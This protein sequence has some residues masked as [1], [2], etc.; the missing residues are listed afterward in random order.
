MVPDA[1]L[2]LASERYAFDKATL[3]FISDSTNQVYGFSRDGKDYI[4]RVSRRPAEAV[5][6]MNAEIDWLY[7]LA[8]R[9]VGVSLPLRAD[10]GGLSVFTTDADS[11]L[12]FILCAFETA[13]GRFWDKNSPE[14]WNGRVFYNWGRAVGELHRLTKDYRP[15][16]PLD[17]RPRFT[18]REALSD[19]IRGCPELCRAADETSAEIMALPSDADSYGLIHCD[20][21]PWNFFIDGDR[22]NLFDFDD[23]LYGWFALDIGVALYHGLW[24]GRKNDAGHDFTNELV[25]RF[26]DGYLSANALDG[27]W[28]S[29][30]PLFMRY[31]QLCK[32]S[33]FFDP[34]HIDAH[35][36]ERIENVVNGVLFTGCELDRSLFRG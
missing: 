31:R 36:R 25:K 32:A 12:G 8:E 20:A 29:K 1:L 2:T 3:R 16:D 7:F 4:L 21:H 30:I 11:G 6:Q 28:L 33:W 5:R 24:W 15:S 35:Q 26:L 23:S 9:G 13:K 10:G 34:A 18:G 27:F 19:S 22:I 17:V 14:L